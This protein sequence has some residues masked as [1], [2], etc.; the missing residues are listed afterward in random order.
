MKKYL[1]C[2]MILLLLIFLIP[3]AV[4]GSVLIGVI[5]V[6]FSTRTEECACYQS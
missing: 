4:I 5:I 2:H 1:L 6:V 3:L